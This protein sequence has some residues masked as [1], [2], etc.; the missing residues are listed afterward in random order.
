MSAFQSY[1][2]A[3]LLGKDPA[4]I[5]KAIAQA[6]NGIVKRKKLPLAIL[7]YE[8]GGQYRCRPLSIYPQSLQDEIVAYLDQLRHISLFDD[9]G[10]EYALR[11]ASLRSTEAHLR[12]YL[13]ALVE[14]GVAP[15]TL[16]SL[17]DA[18]TASNMKSA[19]TGIMKRRGLSDTKDGG[20]H[21]I[22]ATLVAIA[23]HHLKVPEVELNAIQK[24][25]KRAT[26]TVQG[27]S[28]KNR[29]RLGQFHDWENV[30]RLLSLPDTLMARAA[31]NHGS[32]TS[33]LFAMYAVAI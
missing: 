4:K 31:A 9:E 26:P 20:L 32:R 17:K 10:P 24:I 3:H 8:K 5:C 22:S 27:M 2:D 33:A 14:T 11:P 16:L 7:S 21:N 1:L 6:W 23:R 29:D 30:A 12:Q 19:L 28:S 15:E 18:I 25:K 13:D